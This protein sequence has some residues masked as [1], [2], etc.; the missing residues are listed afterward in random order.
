[1]SSGEFNLD[2]LIRN[3]EPILCDKAYVFVT[4]GNSFHYDAMSPL[5][6][7]KEAE[8]TALVLEQRQ[9]V[10]TGIEHEFSC[11]MITLNIH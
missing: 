9:A 3:M 6:T 8:A 5:M 7:F 1:M 2:V 4:V 11:K 10:A